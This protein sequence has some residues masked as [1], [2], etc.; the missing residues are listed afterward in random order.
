LPA[1][2]QVGRSDGWLFNDRIRL[3][4]L[5][6]KSPAN[7]GFFYMSIRW[8][9]DWISNMARNGAI[10]MGSLGVG[11]RIRPGSTQRR[12]VVLAGCWLIASDLLRLW[13]EWL[14]VEPP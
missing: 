11:A 1:E 2:I 5:L 12:A 7:A 4:D 14:E 6:R 9:L 3:I 13:D 10:S 8:V